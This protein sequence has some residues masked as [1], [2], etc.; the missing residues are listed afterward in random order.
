MLPV[1]DKPAIQYIIE[2]AV[3]NRLHNILIVSG[4]GKRSIEDH[5]DRS[6][7]LEQMLTERGRANDAK[8]VAAI[9]ELGNIHYIRQ[10]EPKGL[11][12]A[13]LTA[14][15]HIGDDSFVTMLADDIM[16]PA[17]DLLTSMIEAHRR[18]RVSV[19]ALMPVEASQISQYGCA[20]ISERP[21]GLVQIT[22]VVEK[23]DAE[24]APSNLAITGRYI[25]TPTIFDTLKEVTPGYGGEIQL[26]DGIAK[27][28]ERESVVGV[29][30]KGGRYD[31]GDKVDYLRS[32]IELSLK[33]P[34][35]GP[36]LLPQLATLLD[37]YRSKEEGQ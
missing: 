9:S 3:A 1:V 11:G 26:T 33:R 21:D 19:L 22:G 13:V 27:L 4:R 17:S 7:E 25:F 10:G 29:I 35:L 2:E 8:K 34:D 6:I 16:D 15:D 37:E 36:A 32:V 18:T 24:K 20:A 31:I 30:F 23:P 28:L 14:Q 5:F 12:H